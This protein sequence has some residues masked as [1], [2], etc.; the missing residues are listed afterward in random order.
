MTTDGRL[1]PVSEAPDRKGVGD[2]DEQVW[3]NQQMGWRPGSKMAELYSRTRL[4]R[5][6]CDA[7]LSSQRRLLNTVEDEVKQ[8]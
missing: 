8:S 5:T 3:R 1:A 7:T 6:V 2:A 4:K